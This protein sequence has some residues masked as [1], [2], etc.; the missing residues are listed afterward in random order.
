MELKLSSQDAAFRD[1][2]RAFI[3]ENYPQDMSVP[4]PPPKVWSASGRC[5]NA[6]PS[7][8]ATPAS[9]RM[10]RQPASS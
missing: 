4:I 10:A 8:Q 3:A 5:L 9:Y 7:A 2:V 1:E 6:R